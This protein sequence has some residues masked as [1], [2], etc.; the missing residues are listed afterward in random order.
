MN[1]SRPYS[2]PVRD[3][4]ARAT[5]RRILDAAEQQFLRH[6][7]TAATVAMVAAEA[8]VSKQTVYNSCGSKARLLKRL[9]DVRLVG[10]DEPIPFGERPEIRELESL[11]DPRA[12]LRGYA[13][14][15]G[16]LLQRL[17]PLLS[18]IVAGAAA[19]DQDLVRHLV[20]TDEER[21]IGTT[22]V[23]SRLSQLHA[24]RRGMTQ[25]RARDIL[26]TMN[27]VQ[28]W[29]QLVG[30]RGWT[31]DEYTDWIGSALVDLLLD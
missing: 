3:V 30:R 6:G 19:G 2:S 31:L 25:A 13:R 29:D 7:Y 11:S 12:L 8:G 16:V 20:I 5:E 27:S 1:I 10:D 24:L 14:I 28:V 15:G 22:Q 9:Y 4:A 26:W 17:A 18:L 23:V 21:L